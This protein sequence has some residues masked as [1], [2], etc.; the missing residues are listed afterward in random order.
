MNL[1]TAM[2]TSG[3]YEKE[4]GTCTLVIKT[5]HRFRSGEGYYTTYY[6]LW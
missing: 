1:I 4:N 3:C 6:R 2:K 5:A